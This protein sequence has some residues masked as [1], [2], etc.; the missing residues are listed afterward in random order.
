MTSP[1]GFSRKRI[2]SCAVL[3]ATPALV[4]IFFIQGIQFIRANAPTYD[5]AMHLAAGYSY[6]VTG[7]FRLEP[8]N[9]PLIKTF[10][11]APLF[12]GYRL[13]LRTDTMAW[14]EGAEYLIGHD[15][16]FRSAL[17]PDHMTLLA[18]LPNLLLG[19]FLLAVIGWWAYRLWGFGAALLAMSLAC[20]EPNLVAHSSLVT[21]D[22]GASLFTCLAVYL[23]WEYRRSHSIWL[24][25]GVGISLGIA[26]VCKFSTILLVPIIGAIIALSTFLDSTEHFSFFH[27]R[28]ETQLRQWLFQAAAEFLVILLVAAAFIPSAYFF[29][30]FQS[31]LSGFLRFATLAQG[32]QAAF[33]LGQV[34]YHGSWAY[35]PV[36]FLIKTPIGT[37]LLIAASLMFY[38]HGT[39]LRWHGAIFLLFPVIFIFLAMTQSKV[40]IGVRHIL[41]VYPFLLIL[42]GRLATVAFERRRMRFLL[43]GMPMMLTALSA[44]RIAPH[45]LAYFNEFVGG[46]DQGYRYLSDSNLD[47][48][49]D[50]RGVRAYMAKENLPIVYLSYFGTAPP[51]YYGIRYQYVPGSWPLEWPPPSDKVPDTAPRKV[52]A[53]SVYN[54]QD[55]ANPFNPLFRWL[56]IRQPVA[57]IGYS[58]FIYDLT[59]DQ[60]GLRR[61]SE[62]YVKA[63][64]TPPP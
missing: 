34:L 56:W 62:T 64:I 36:A 63:G 4:V 60:E 9:P 50:L 59:N 31:W 49:Q 18:R 33:F 8:Q 7:D 45:H 14:H 35:Y 24:L 21:T 40:N 28:R 5:E 27:E 61:L 47:W 58:I 51:S 54:L 2:K 29:Q 53:I 13:P 10:L 41:P 38:R 44:L 39:S 52:L 16:L 23:L 55:V 32:G 11:A 19:G 15:F 25:A 42:A 22:T 43:I 6:L 1:W 20:V 26:L 12:F 30:G 3:A 46:P 17:P 48:G 57:K 37:L